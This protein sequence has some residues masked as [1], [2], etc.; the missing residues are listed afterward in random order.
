MLGMLEIMRAYHEVNKK[1]YTQEEKEN[2]L[3]SV[4]EKILG[5]K[6]Q[7]D[8]IWYGKEI[9]GWRSRP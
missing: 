2:T 8:I 7:Y 1:G 3:F 9:V 4:Y 6:F 5:F